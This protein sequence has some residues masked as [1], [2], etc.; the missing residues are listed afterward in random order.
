EENDKLFGGAN[1]VGRTVRIMDRDFKVI[2]VIA[3]WR[4]SIRIYDLTQMYIAPPEK[5]F[6]PFNLMPPMRIRTGGNVDGW[7]SSPTSGFDGFLAS[8]SCWLQFW[9]ELPTEAKRH[10]YEDYLTAYVMEQ[11]KAGRFGRPV[12]NRLTAV[13]PWMVEQ[14]VVPDET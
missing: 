8:E 1:S 10:E 5:L 3:H 12:N 11:K 7:K 6:I 13:L 14:G 4:P 2:G 9:V